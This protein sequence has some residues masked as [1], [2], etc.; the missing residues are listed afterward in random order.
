M[1]VAEGVD[2]L[3]L[4]GIWR[5]NP[6]RL[7][8]VLLRDGPQ[9][10]LVDTGFPGSADALR[11][12][13]QEVGVAFAHLRVILLTHQDLDHIGNAPVIVR[14]SGAE[15]WAHPEDAPF[16]EGV[17][18][19]LKFN[20]QGLPPEVVQNPP[21]VKVGRHLTDGEYIPV[22]GGLRVVHTPGHTPGHLSLYLE[23]PRILIA[24]DAL[25]VVDGELHGPRP[26]VTPDMPTAMASVRK[27]AALE[28]D[29][30]VCY[31][32]GVFGPG[33]APRLRS[34]ADA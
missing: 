15:V 8:P 20:P 13:L 23:A 3:A 21:T 11:A 29:L 27:L 26:D 14:E 12:A 1:R 32:G 24:G 18:P 33:A 6:V 16:I 7:H 34:L 4:E 22:C 28:P 25:R 10:L 19:F 31:H 2:V 30:V 17:R 5:G 9:V